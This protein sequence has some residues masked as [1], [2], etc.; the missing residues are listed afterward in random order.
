M[1][2]IPPSPPPP[3]IVVAPVVVFDMGVLLLSTGKLPFTTYI[4]PGK[5]NKKNGHIIIDPRTKEGFR[6]YAES[7][8][9]MWGIWENALIIESQNY[10]L[11]DMGG[12]SGNKE[13][14]VEADPLTMVAG[15]RQKGDPE[16]FHGIVGYILQARE[17]L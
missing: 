3:V 5:D 6:T 4:T 14:I 10:E 17:V 9:D 7:K 2:E 1:E 15:Y 16:S 12:G 11:S 13:I 8:G